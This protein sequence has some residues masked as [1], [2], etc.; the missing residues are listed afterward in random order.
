MRTLCFRRR[1][2]GLLYSVGALIDKSGGALDD[3]EFETFSAER[4]V[5]GIASS[6]KKYGTADFANALAIH[7]GTRRRQPL[8]FPAPSRTSSGP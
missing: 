7:Y 3:L 6:A 5:A 8:K 2:L 1:Q 4:D